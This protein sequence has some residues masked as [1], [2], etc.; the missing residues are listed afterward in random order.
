MC[1]GRW[2]CCEGG[3]SRSEQAGAGGE[4]QGR[5]SLRVTRGAF[6]THPPCGPAQPREIKHQNF[7]KASLVIPKFTQRGDGQSQPRLLGRQRKEGAPGPSSVRPSHPS[8]LGH[9]NAPPQ[10]AGVSK[11]T[12]LCRWP[13]K[14]VVLEA[15]AAQT[16]QRATG[17]RG[18]EQSGH[19]PL[20]PFF[21][22][23]SPLS[24]PPPRTPPQN[25]TSSQG[26]SCP[27][28]KHTQRTY[29]AQG[30]GAQSG[31]WRLVPT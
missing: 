31:R 13:P 27:F 22:V 29:C 14:L 24:T 30:P 6:R 15:P 4:G 25:P 12:W 26:A 18:S 28:S 20:S 3:W 19:L 1:C 2:S 17:E 8:L 10:R 11:R 9:A 23:T 7:Q 21:L 5:L 16:S